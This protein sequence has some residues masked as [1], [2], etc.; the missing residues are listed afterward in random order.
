MIKPMEVLARNIPDNE[1]VKMD[2]ISHMTTI[3][4]P[5]ET[6]ELILRFLQKRFIG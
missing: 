2:G 1:F 5:E 3:E 4:A 6:L